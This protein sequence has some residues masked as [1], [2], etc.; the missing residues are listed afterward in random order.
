MI[1]IHDALKVVKGLEMSE[2][3]REELSVLV[4]YNIYAYEVT[5]LVDEGVIVEAAH[6]KVI[7]QYLAEIRLREEHREGRS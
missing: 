3:E 5:R 4:T 7:K 1:T 2:S 6:E